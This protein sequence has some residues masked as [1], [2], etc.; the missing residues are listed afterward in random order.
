[1]IREE[2]EGKVRDN[3]EAWNRQDAAGT[4][5]IVAPDCVYID[6]NVEMRGR[7]AMQAA[8]QAYFDAFPDL[9]LELD[10]LYVDGNTVIAEWRSSGTHEGELMGIP[11]TG[12]R[13]EARGVLIDEFGDDGL[14]HRGVLC[15]D[16]VKL[17]QDLGVMPVP[18]E[19]G[20]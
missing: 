8:A 6:N 3:L 4:V 10:R 19:A 20:A 11:A 18:S 2:L 16:T 7:E 1:M 12:A 13:A 17:L 9:H 14:L 5:E 15:W